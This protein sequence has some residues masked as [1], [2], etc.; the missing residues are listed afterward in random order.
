MD[1]KKKTLNRLLLYWLF[2]FGIA[3]A[4]FFA[5]ICTGH[6]WDEA[7]MSFQQLVGLG[8]LAPLIA[9]IL[10]RFFTKEGFALDGEN[11]M[12]LGIHFENKKWIFYV[13]AIGL[14]FIYREVGNLI[15]LAVCPGLFDASYPETMGVESGLINIMPLAAMINGTL[16]SFAAL[17]EEGG[18]RGYMIPKMTELMGR[19]K[20]LLLGGIIWGLWHAPLTCVGHNFGRDYWGFPVVGILVM[21]LMCIFLGVILTFLVEKTGSVW[22][23]AFLHGVNNGGTG[24]LS[25]YMNGE[26]LGNP[27][28]VMFSRTMGLLVPLAVIAGICFWNM[29]KKEKNVEE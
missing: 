3:W 19:K 20:A 28:M 24:I 29:T 27:N 12:M 8:M 5:F 14:P 7:D 2:S 18:W 13:M 11:S 21:C 17:G 15:S 10:T 4:I 26:K 22:P 25:C 23:A 16:L 9:H 6:T 1:N